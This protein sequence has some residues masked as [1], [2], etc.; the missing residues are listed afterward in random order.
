MNRIVR[1][2]RF[3][4]LCLT[5]GFYAAAGGA[6]VLSSPHI[7]GLSLNGGVHALSSANLL[8]T[9]THSPAEFGT[10]DYTVTTIS[11]TSFMADDNSGWGTALCCLSRY[12]SG[13]NGIFYTSV[14]IPTGA[15]ID[16]I[17][18]ESYSSCPGIVGVELWQV[19]N[20]SDS[21]AATFSSTA[22]GY[23]VDYNASPLG[24][25][26]TNSNNNALAL[27]V[28]LAGSGC[29]NYPAFS[30]VEIWWRRVVSPPPGVASFSDV[31]T[32]HPFFQFVE[33]IHAAGITN[34]YPDGRFGVNDPIT[35]GQMA[36]YLAAALGLHWPN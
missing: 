27:E 10:K 6:Q 20:G 8:P 30:W 33:A 31:P 35:R 26:L 12:F 16:Y 13:G 23:G 9:T 17:G 22:H 28:E 21:G 25:Q 34:G 4:A 14:S 19:Y 1:T 29:V 11:A 15:V 18:L 36:V 24:W 5:A 7:E 32:N 3:V 2:S